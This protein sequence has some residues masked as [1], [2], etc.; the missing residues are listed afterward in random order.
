M[1]WEANS[2]SKGLLYSNIYSIQGLMPSG[3][4]V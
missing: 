4:R 2:K 3:G 1:M